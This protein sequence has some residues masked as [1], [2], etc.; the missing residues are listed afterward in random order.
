MYWATLF[1]SPFL[2]A[3][4]HYANCKGMTNAGKT[5]KFGWTWD[6]MYF[7]TSEHRRGIFAVNFLGDD[8]FSVPETNSSPLRIKGWKMKFLLG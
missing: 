1:T 8:N 6:V 7:G 5:P 3:T 4:L 2:I